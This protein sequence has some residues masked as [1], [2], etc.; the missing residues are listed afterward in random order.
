MKTIGIC[1]VIK[2][3]HTN[4]HFARLLRNAAAN[5]ARELVTPA[6]VIG[7]PAMLKKQAW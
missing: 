1:E 4:R 7:V 5:K 2:A 6:A 3:K